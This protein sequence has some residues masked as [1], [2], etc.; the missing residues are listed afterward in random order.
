[1]AGNDKLP[2]G[3][4]E[5]LEDVIAGESKICKV[6]GQNGR[7]YYR[8]YKIQDIAANCT[9]EEVAYLLF[10][11][12]LPT[13]KELDQFTKRLSGMREIPQYLIGILKSL[14]KGTTP[15]DA[16]RTGVSALSGGDPSVKDK[17][18]YATIAE[19][20]TAKFPTIVAYYYRI[21]NG[22]DIVHPDQSLSHAANFL[23]MVNGKKPGKEGASAMNMDLVLH[24]EH[25]FNASTFGTRITASTLSDMYSDMTTGIGILKGP[26]HGG[27]AQEVITQFNEIG[28]VEN[29]EPYIKNKLATHGKVMGIG[30]RVYKVYDPRAIILKKEA[31]SFSEASGDMKLFDMANKIEEIMAREKKLYPNVDFFSPIVYNAGGLPAELYSPIFAISRVTGWA[32][33]A[34]EQYGDNR[35]IRPLSYYTGQ[36]DLKFVPIEKRQ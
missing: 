12:K 16:L 19:S 7:L 15:M 22:L 30:H 10:Y 36:V 21:S 23:Y 17:K 31:K 25:E 29:V 14:P 1:M 13:G 5:G 6:D 24:A 26:L 33:H 20:L 3:F 28:S 35:L 8:G 2:E 11:Q 9:F 4:K 27:A 34:M 32:A 18:D